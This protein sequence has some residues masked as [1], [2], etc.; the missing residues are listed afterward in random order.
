MRAAVL[1][2]PKKL[3]VRDVPTPTPAR[4]EVLVRVRRASIC[5]TDYAMFSGDLGRPLPLILGHEAAGEVAAVGEGVVGIAT[6]QHVTIQPNFA[7]GRCETCARGK[8]NVCPDKVRLGLDVNGVFADYVCVPRQYVWPLP[9]GLDLSIA[10]LSEPLSVAL[11][12]IGMAPPRPGDRVL[13]FG[14]GA[15]GL[16]FVRLAALAGA[17]VAAIDVAPRRLAAARAL[18]ASRTFGSVDECAREAGGFVTAYE[19]SVYGNPHF[20]STNGY[21][22]RRLAAIAMGGSTRFRAA[23]AA[24]AVALV[25]SKLAPGETTDGAVFFSNDG[26]PLIGGKIVVRTNTDVFEFKPE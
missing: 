9:P 8:E 22:Q 19:T 7:C 26:K 12:G 25:R 18:G 4:D 13:V 16:F 2:E 14:A 1:V 23:A 6:G 10:T 21:E 5:G 20:K 15:I 11:H 3:E 17:T 24:S